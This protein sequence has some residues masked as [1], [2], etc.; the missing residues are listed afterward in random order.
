[1]LNLEAV[2][3]TRDWEIM[4]CSAYASEGLLEGFDWVALDVAS[5]I[6]MLD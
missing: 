6:D 5:Q 3:I 1:M 2:D 4:G